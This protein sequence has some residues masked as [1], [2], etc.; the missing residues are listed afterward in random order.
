MVGK[1]ERM[2]EPDVRRTMRSTIIRAIGRTAAAFAKGGD[3]VFL[4]GVVGP[5][6]LPTLVR[7]M[8]W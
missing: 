1:P 5:G 8:R 6:F 4:D 3:T 2:Q 7:E